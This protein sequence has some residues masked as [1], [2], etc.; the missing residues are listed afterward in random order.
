MHNV[1]RKRDAMVWISESSPKSAEPARSTVNR[2]ERKWNREVMITFQLTGWV[3][4]NQFGLGRVIDRWAN[5]IKDEK[6]RC[7]IH[8]I[9]C[10]WSGRV[11]MRERERER[12]KTT[13]SIPVLMVAGI[14]IGKRAHQRI[15]IMLEGRQHNQKATRARQEPHALPIMRR[16]TQRV[17]ITGQ[18]LQSLNIFFP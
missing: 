16:Y 15:T 4:W 14:L 5:D 12:K 6:E 3:D 11:Q 7:P 2:R 13:S 18:W 17:D 9:A 8:S 1:K 10:C